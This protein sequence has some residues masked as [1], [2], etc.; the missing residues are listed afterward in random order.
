[1]YVYT[2]VYSHD[3]SLTLINLLLFIC[4]IFNECSHRMCAD[5]TRVSFV[6]NNLTLNILSISNE[7][8][9]H[10]RRRTLS[11]KFQFQHPLNHRP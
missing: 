10:R 8:K 3:E 11:N 9:T 5:I 4:G 1:M 7:K 6:T 2:T